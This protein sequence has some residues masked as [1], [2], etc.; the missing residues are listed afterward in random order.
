MAGEDIQVKAP[1][2][3]LVIRHGRDYLGC[4]KSNGEKIINHVP[5]ERRV[6][7]KS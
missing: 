3:I 5:K 7:I 4:A 1:L 2:G 6:R